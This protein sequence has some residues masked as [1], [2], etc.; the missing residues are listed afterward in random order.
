MMLAKT[1]PKTLIS[2]DTIFLFTKEALKYGETIH[3]KVD[4]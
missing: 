1:T 2:I 3:E 4:V